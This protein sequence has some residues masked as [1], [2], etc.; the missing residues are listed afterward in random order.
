MR[1]CLI[2][3]HVE[4]WLREELDDLEWPAKGDAT[5]AF[6]GLRAPRLQAVVNEVMRL[7]PP[8]G[9]FFRRT[10]RPIELANIHIPKG[11]VVQVAL[12]SSNRAGASEL[13][14]FRPERHL[15]GSNNPTL[16]PFGGG[17]RVCLGKALAELEI[18]LMVVGLL[19]QVQLS[20]AVDQDLDLQLIPSPSPKDGLKVVARHYAPD[21][22][23]G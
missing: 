15:D 17:D 23:R 10:C 20:L 7:T 3:P 6:D 11:H 18:R 2:E 8:V 9:G 12:A 21:D 5:T 13:N 19:K 1:A 16:L 14:E 4:P 22:A